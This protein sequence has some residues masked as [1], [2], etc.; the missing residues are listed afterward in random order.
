MVPLTEADAEDM[1]VGQPKS[2]TQ[3]FSIPQPKRKSKP[4]DPPSSPP[5]APAAQSS[6]P[7]PGMAPPGQGSMAPGMGMGMGMGIQ[8]PVAGAPPSMAP[9]MQS[10]PGTM[11]HAQGTQGNRAQSYRVFA[12][13]AGLMF[14]V[15]SALVVTVALI[16][17]AAYFSTQDSSTAANDPMPARE[18]PKSPVVDTGEAKPPPP[19]KPSPRPRPRPSGGGGA[20]PKPAAPAPPPP[21]PPPAAAG[22]VTVIIPASESFTGVEVRCPDGF[23]DRA[24]FA[25]G[26][27]TIANVPN[28]QC[29]MFFKGGLPAKNV[30]RGGETKNCT[31]TGGQAVCK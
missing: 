24:A 2:A 21:A 8:G 29:D 9:P 15:M 12:I 18:R 16:G 13:V 27:A 10:H 1:D 6:A 19:I 20:A 7:P 14:M 17:G 11:P 3:F 23:R 22:Q 30:I 31:F 4:A 25:G 28:L 26:K 5:A